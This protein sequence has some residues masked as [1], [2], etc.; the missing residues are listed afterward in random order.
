MG[1]SPWSDSLSCDDGKRQGSGSGLLRH[2]FL[3][4]LPQRL[5][6]LLSCAD[7]ASQD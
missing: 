5:L 6:L 7:G 1:Q 4:G 2:L 3:L